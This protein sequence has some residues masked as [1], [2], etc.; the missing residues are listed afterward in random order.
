M[1]K[2]SSGFKDSPA[3][4][5]FRSPKILKKSCVL[6]CRDYTHPDLELRSLRNLSPLSRKRQGGTAKIT[7]HSK[8]LFKFVVQKERAC[9]RRKQ[10]YFLPPNLDLI[11]NMSI[12]C[13]WQEESGRA[14]DTS[15][16]L[17][18]G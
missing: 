1:T 15:S 3:N 12:T 6:F 5:L 9:Q 13:R 17:K 2:D 16:E 14:A 4:S 7:I 10:R 11:D 18:I 8:K